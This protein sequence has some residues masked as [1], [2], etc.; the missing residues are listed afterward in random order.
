L[1]HG[2][3]SSNLLLHV[4]ND[5]LD[6]V[7]GSYLVHDNSGRKYIFKP[8]D[9]EAFDESLNENGKTVRMAKKKGIKWGQTAAKEFAA[10]ILDR[11]WAGVQPTTV[12]GGQ[13]LSSVKN[14]QRNEKGVADLTLYKKKC[15]DV[16]LKKTSGERNHDDSRM[17]TKFTQNQETCLSSNAEHTSYSRHRD[18]K[19]V[20]YRH[21]QSHHDAQGS[22]LVSKRAYMP[23]ALRRRM[24]I[25]Q[26]QI[27][28]S[29]SSSPPQNNERPTRHRTS[30]VPP[31]IRRK[32]MQI[33]GGG[34]KSSKA[35]IP[36]RNEI[37]PQLP[38]AAA[39]ARENKALQSTSTIAPSEQSGKWANELGENRSDRFLK[40]RYV[41]SPP[42]FG[43]LQAFID[44]IGSAEDI[45]PSKFSVED[46]HRIG[47]LDIRLCNLD[48]HLGNILVSRMKQPGIATTSIQQR[49]ALKSKR[50]DDGKDSSA[51]D[52][53]ATPSSASSFSDYKLIPIDHAYILPDFRHIEEVNFEWL[54]WKQTRVPF[55]EE[56]KRYIRLLD[57]FAD[58]AKLRALRLEE[59]SAM[60]VIITTLFLKECVNRNMTLWDIGDA[61][62]RQGMGTNPSFLEKIV[63]SAMN[64]YESE[65]KKIMSVGIVD[66]DEVSKSRYDLRRD[67]KFR[68]F[69][70][71]FQDAMKIQLDGQSFG[72]MT[73]HHVQRGATPVSL[74]T[75]KLI[76]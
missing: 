2:Q 46:V 15:V 58:A 12:T 32:M 40:F 34:E 31:A 54:H 50:G 36:F 35:L 53:A 10:Y 24:M 26:Q 43:S 69:L 21:R 47:V 5:H 55:S 29:S 14:T 39:A 8:N 56:T 27:S 20:N 63:R 16:S 6:G 38:A 64:Q 59:A 4:D 73:M 49:K 19:N 25:Q 37:G 28:S 41:A 68:V 48:R 66:F 62:Q 22:P 13:L 17:L 11:G 51:A 9:E 72:E 65:S 71:C 1:Q 18:G 57:P 45:G 3:S 75:N 74:P 60:T 76:H 7:G 52:P 23:P 67:F 33:G 30:Y 42:K 70:K 44:N 61:M